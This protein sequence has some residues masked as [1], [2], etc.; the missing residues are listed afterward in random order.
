MIVGLSAICSIDKSVVKYAIEISICYSWIEKDELVAQGPLWYRPFHF[1]F[2]FYFFYYSLTHCLSLSPFVLIFQGPPVDREPYCQSVVHQI[3]PSGMTRATQGGSKCS[4]VFP[5][6]YTIYR[7]QIEML[8][9]TSALF[10]YVCMHQKPISASF[11]FNDPKVDPDDWSR[12]RT[13]KEAS[14]VGRR[15]QALRGD[16]HGA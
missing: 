1:Y 6:T 9:F 2:I 16:P 13:T 12:L 8:P 3:A 10:T 4:M 5:Q 7:P 15:F 11:F 14:L